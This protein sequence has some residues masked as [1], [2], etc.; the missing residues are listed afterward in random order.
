MAKDV[1]FQFDIIVSLPK[2][3]GDEDVIIDALF[4]VGCDDAVVGLGFSGLVG[5]GFTRGGENAEVVI[6][7]AVRQVLSALPEGAQLR[8]VKPDLVSLPDVA[9]RLSVSRQSLQN[10]GMS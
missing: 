5:L 10:R 9:A 8:E 6:S 4:E 2:G 1:E 7:A 3:A